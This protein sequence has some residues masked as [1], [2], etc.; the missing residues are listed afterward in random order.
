MRWSHLI[1]IGAVALLG[2]CL[3]SVTI[4]AQ[5]TSLKEACHGKDQPMAGVATFSVWR[6]GE[7]DRAKYAI[8]KGD[9]LMKESNELEAA[10]AAA[11]FIC[12]GRGLKLNTPEFNACAAEGSRAALTA[13]AQLR[14]QENL[15]AQ[16]RAQQVADA[17]AQAGAA[18]QAAQPAPP[19]TVNIRTNCTSTRMGSFVNTNCF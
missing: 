10:Q 8:Y 17:F 18:I 7:G 15:Q 6:C 9:A 19:Q 13:T 12:I 14:G 1:V 11:G 16:I 4:P 3:R 2:G 5:L